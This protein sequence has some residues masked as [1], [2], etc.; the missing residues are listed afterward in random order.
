[1]YASVGFGF[2]PDTVFGSSG[3][4]GAGTQQKLI[5]T[6]GFRGA[7]THNWDPYWNTS[8]YGS[9][10]QIHWSSGAAA[11]VCGGTVDGLT[12][13]GTARTVAG[14]AGIG[15]LA[16]VCN[17]DYNIA[18]LGIITRWTPVKNLTFSADLTWTGLDQKMFGTV[19]APSATIG[20]PALVYEL[21]DQQNVVL[22][23]RAQRN[24]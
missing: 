12:F 16:A 6:W 20:K 13:V 9:W 23:L 8:I 19:V 7:Y 14:L 24:W 11:L 1:A 22:L 17:P 3:A 10:S 5:Q 15:G 21:K 18:S 4:I 2:A